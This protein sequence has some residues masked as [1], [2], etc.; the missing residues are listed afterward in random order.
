LCALGNRH[1]VA[2]LEF[3]SHVTLV[4]DTDVSVTST[5]LLFCHCTNNA[6]GAVIGA[7]YFPDV[8]P[9]RSL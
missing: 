1:F 6:K 3:R 4:R 7:P 9:R 8:A 5:A 2:N